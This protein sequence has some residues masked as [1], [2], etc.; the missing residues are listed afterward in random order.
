MFYRRGLPSTQPI[1]YRLGDSPLPIFFRSSRGRS[2]ILTWS[3]VSGVLRP[4]GGKCG[5]SMVRPCRRLKGDK[6]TDKRRQG[7]SF[8]GS[9]EISS[10]REWN[11]PFIPKPKSSTLDAFVPIVETYFSN[12]ATVSPVRTGYSF[13]SF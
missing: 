1:P 13:L 8:L 10:S 3:S 4:E 5:V 12:V 7:T 6:H 11:P 2:F 9:V